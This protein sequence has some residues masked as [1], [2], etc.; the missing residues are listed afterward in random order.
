MSDS[1][2]ATEERFLRLANA[3]RRLIPDARQAA[4]EQA[5]REWSA[6]HPAESAPIARA[7][8]EDFGV[9]LE[10]TR[11]ETKWVAAMDAFCAADPVL[12]SATRA[13][14]MVR[15]NAEELRSRQAAG[16]K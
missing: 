13:S 16:G 10:R 6:A 11:R 9:W 3:A 5:F 14:E 8:G 2:R 7:D 12:K 1:T 15:G 4:I